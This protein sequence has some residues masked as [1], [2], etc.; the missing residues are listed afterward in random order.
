M[1]FTKAAAAQ[2]SHTHLA[3]NMFQMTNVQSFHPRGDP[4]P[5][6][7]SYLAMYPSLNYICTGAATGLATSNDHCKCSWLL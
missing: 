5:G 7:C 4:P 6:G 2:G 1:E 3:L